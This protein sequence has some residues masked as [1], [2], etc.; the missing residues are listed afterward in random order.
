MIVFTREL[1]VPEVVVHGINASSVSYLSYFMFG[2]L[3]VLI[4]T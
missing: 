2:L 3:I 1:N 4:F